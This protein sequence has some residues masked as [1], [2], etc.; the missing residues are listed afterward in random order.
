[1]MP[2]P[3]RPVTVAAAVPAAVTAALT[4]ALT[5]A[6]AAAVR[7]ALAMPRRYLPPTRH[8]LA[9]LLAASC[10]QAQAQANAQ[11][12]G[13]AAQGAFPSRPLRIV[14]PYTPGAINDILARQVGRKLS[15]NLGQPVIIEN[16][17]GGNTVIGTDFVAKA[18]AD[19]YT[20][21]QVPGAH[22]INATLVPRLPY[23]PV[24]SFAFVTLAA[25][26]PFVLVANP[27]LEAKTFAELLAAAR[28]SPGKYSYGSTGNGGNAHL[29][30]EMLKGMAKIDL[31]HTPYKGA[32]QA[33]SD[34]IGGQV[35]LMFA[36]YSAA[37]GHLNTGRLRALAVTSARR[38]PV[39]PALPTIAE[40]GIGPYEA[41]GW[42]GYA[43]PAATPRPIVDKLNA[44]I[45]KALRSPELRTHFQPE[46]LELLGSTPEEFS[47]Y[48][49]REIITWA[50]V[51]RAG[52]IKAE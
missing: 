51:I 52:N 45:N 30:G 4:A 43:V 19:G 11:A 17:P 2:R 13:S 23:E 12:P 22:A 49:N 34:I 40:S 20:L 38:W 48:L 31:L 47:R 29:M 9:L 7:P 46:G 21:L 18:P 1:M 15:E 41:V 25:S 42:W 16:K 37:V 8:L 10:V 6:V 44:E 27:R 36:T 33:M 26:A 35:D 39:L 24:K 32:A 3:T 28:A 14:V 5:A 50:G